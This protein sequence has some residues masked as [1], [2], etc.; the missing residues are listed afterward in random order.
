MEANDLP[1]VHFWH[2]S[3]EIHSTYKVCANVKFIL[4]YKK[5]TKKDRVGF[6]LT[7]VGKS[8]CAAF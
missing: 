8:K 7:T 6:H 1:I 4:Q 3:H 2:I 5:E